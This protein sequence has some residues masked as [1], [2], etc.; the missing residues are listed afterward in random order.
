MM[1]VDVYIGGMEHATLH[2]LYAR[3]IH[4]FL[5]KKGLIG[6]INVENK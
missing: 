2:L 1:P 4:K 3:F 5:Y 6:E